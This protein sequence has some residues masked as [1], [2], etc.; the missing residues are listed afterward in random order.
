MMLQ[1]DIIDCCFFTLIELVCVLS[2]CPHG[3]CLVVGV[4]LDYRPAEGSQLMM[5]KENVQHVDE[6]NAVLERI[7]A[8]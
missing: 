6:V 5:R 4:C 8:K 7:L 3:F 1:D 2:R